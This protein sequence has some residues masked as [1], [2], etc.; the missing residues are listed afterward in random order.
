VP[1]QSS[2]ERETIDTQLRI[3]QTCTDGRMKRYS[4]LF[5][6]KTA[7][8][9]GPE[10]RREGPRNDKKYCESQENQPTMLHIVTFSSVPGTAAQRERAILF[11]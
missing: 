9:D 7:S 6:V 1:P 3:L 2:V 4:L 5:S 10:T 8:L 11:R